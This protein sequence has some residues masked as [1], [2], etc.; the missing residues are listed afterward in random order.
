M[1]KLRANTP[2][3]IGLNTVVC[4]I[5]YKQDADDLP[6]SDVLMFFFEDGGFAVR[7]SATESK[8]KFYYGF[9]GKSMDEVYKKFCQT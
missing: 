2:A 4:V 8:I 6:K 5:D 3:T 9:D 1:E 7:S